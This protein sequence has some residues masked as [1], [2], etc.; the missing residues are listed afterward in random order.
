MR[1]RRSSAAGSAGGLEGVELEAM[2]AADRAAEKARACYGGDP[3]WLL[4]ICRARIVFPSAAALLRGAAA[5][6]NAGAAGGPGA[7]A[8]VVRVRNGFEADGVF[9]LGFR[10]GHWRRRACGGAEVDYG[11]VGR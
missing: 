9:A 8:R 7:G 5:V 2:K 11:G 3:S 1:R 10:V 4:D 6:L